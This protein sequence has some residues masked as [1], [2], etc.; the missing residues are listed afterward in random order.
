MFKR[1]LDSIK[2]FFGFRNNRQTEFDEA[3]LSI[4]KAVADSRLYL[5]AKEPEQMDPDQGKE[6][7]HAWSE[8]AVKINRFN[9]ELREDCL[10]L[11][12]IFSGF[13]SWD[14]EHIR[15]HLAQV[16][17]TF[18]AACESLKEQGKLF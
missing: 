18:S 3:M 2:A 17:A 4:L 1:A 12:R 15:A 6:L 14:S 7:A 13:D 16:D 10:V 8:A 9:D 11:T 5:A